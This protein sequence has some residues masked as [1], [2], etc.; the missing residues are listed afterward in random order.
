MDARHHGEAEVISMDNKAKLIGSAETGFLFLLSYAVIHY[1]LLIASKANLFESSYSRS[2]LGRWHPHLELPYLLAVVSGLAAA[3]ILWEKV[4]RKINFKEIGFTLPKHLGTELIAAASLF[5][6]FAGYSHLFLSRR[7][8]LLSWE[9][10]VIISLCTRWL[11]VASAEEVLYRG[12]IQRRL[13][14]IWGKYCGLILA[15]ALFAFVGHWQAPL[16]D[17]ALFRLP[18]GVIL[19]Y[20]YLR[21]NSLLMPI[22]MHWWF[23]VLF[24]S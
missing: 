20:L 23:N 18:F 22:T 5:L 10:P 2:F 11:V 17:N 12:I 8:T 4:I 9:A 15:S 21:S 3:P 7:F 14:R 13:S 24:V 16:V 19:G 1:T 6:V